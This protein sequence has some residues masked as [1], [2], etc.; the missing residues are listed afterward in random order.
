MDKKKFGQFI[1]E[2]RTKKDLHRQKAYMLD[3][4]YAR[5]RKHF[6]LTYMAGLT[7][8]TMLLL[9]VGIFKKGRNN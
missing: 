4:Q 9:I 5:I 1:K 2:S 6:L 7:L 8:L 3:E